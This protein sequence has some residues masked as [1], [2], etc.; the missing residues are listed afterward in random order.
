MEDFTPTKTISEVWAD[1]QLRKIF[2]DVINQTQLKKCRQLRGPFVRKLNDHVKKGLTDAEI[3]S[4]MREFIEN[5]PVETRRHIQHQGHYRGLNRSAKIIDFAKQFGPPTIER[6]LDIGCADGSITKILRQKLD[7]NQENVHG[8]DICPTASNGF[9]FNLIDETADSVTLPYPDKH[10]DIVYA[11]MSFHH[12]RK[13]PEM[14]SEIY[15]VLRNDGLL[16]VREHDCINIGLSK[17][18]DVVHGFYS[19]VWCTPQEHVNFQEEYFG[20]Y[21]T[22]QDFDDLISSTTKLVRVFG[23]NRQET[24]P[25]Y[26]YGKIVNPMKHYWAVYRKEKEAEAVEIIIEKINSE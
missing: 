22:A 24:Y 2:L 16:I 9:T 1:F 12:I 4:Y 6:V 21:R 7:L 17:I 8:C 25:T 10:F 18:L 5:L 15:R 19:M 14:L 23:T 26:Y 20:Q 11:L 13:L 3:Y